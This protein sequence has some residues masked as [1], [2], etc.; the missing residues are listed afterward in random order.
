MATEIWEDNMFKP[1]STI[2]RRSMLKFVLATASTAA[3]P[4]IASANPASTPPRD[5]A[6]GQAGG[7]RQHGTIRAKAR[8]KWL[9]SN[10][11]IQIGSLP[12]NRK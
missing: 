4:T 7:R 11:R 2:S 9:L 6:T 10:F 1:P 8:K 5:A 12:V 3:L